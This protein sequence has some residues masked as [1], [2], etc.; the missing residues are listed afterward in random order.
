[1]SKRY[2]GRRLSWWR[3][4]IL[5]GVLGVL[6]FASVE[7]WRWFED[8]QT[9]ANSDPWT[10]GYVDV[11]TTP[12]YAFEEVSDTDLKNITLAFVVASKTDPCEPSWGGAYSL[13]QA[14]V[15]VDLDRRLARLRDLGGSAQ[16][17]FGGAAN[18]D[19][20]V[21]CE[22][23][24]KLEKA[25]GSVIERYE[26]TTVDLDI[27]GDFLTDLP[28]IERQARAFA[29]LQ[30]ER[31]TGD[32]PLDVW[33][34]LPVA[35]TGLTDAG[36]DAVT[37][38]LEAGVDLAGVNAMTMNYGDTAVAEKPFIDVIT[39]SLQQTHRQLG[40][41]YGRQGIQLGSATLWSKLGA[42]PMIGQNDVRAE[43]F[44]I[45]DAQQLN[46]FSVE[47]GLER[48]SFWSINR[49]QTCAPNYPDVRTVSNSCSGVDQGD[50]TFAAI[51]AQNRPGTLDAVFGPGTTPEPTETDPAAA[52]DPKTSPYPI[53]DE[54][55]AY[56]AESKVV[57]RHNVYQAKWWTQGDAP[58]NPVLQ[59]SESPWTLIGPVLPGET[60]VPVPTLAPGIL[61][62]W[63]KDATY[64]SGDRVMFLDVPYQ[65]RWWTQGDSPD[66]SKVLP[67]SSPWRPLT[68]TEIMS[69]QKTATPTPAP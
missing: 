56:P 36:T 62:E 37:A 24:T 47:Q 19:L 22:D 60:P 23:S 7:G 48:V 32:A 2:P 34:T 14:G 5:V 12:F 64:V 33:L 51:L 43:I 3:L 4:T 68:A 61:P 66:A 65:A 6:G 20:A 53:W 69:L 63:Q 44:T 58:D 54:N 39:E 1:M 31:K 9:A 55:A 45:A 40:V 15:E 35:P 8:V 27:E 10:D 49:D 25:Y 17:S 26:T 18:S 21:G 52:D 59:I 29:S 67:D 41:L 57:W 38:F 28:A 46:A 11:T 16:V 30:G 50:A 42:T 13:Q